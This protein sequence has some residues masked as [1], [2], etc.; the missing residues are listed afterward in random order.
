MNTN[1]FK[2]FPFVLILILLSHFLLVFFAVLPG[3]ISPAIILDGSLFAMFG[4][5]ILIILPGL[6][7]DAENFA[8][9]FIGL[10]SLQMLSMLALIASL[11]FGK[12]SDPRYWAFTSIILFSLLLMIQSILFI[13]EVNKK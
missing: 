2:F 10:T 3:E 11:I 8:L 7:K 9:R 1:F 5:G 12:F 4:L 6:K 13:K